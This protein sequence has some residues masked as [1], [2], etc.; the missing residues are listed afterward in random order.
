MKYCKKCLQPDTRPNTVF[1]DNGIC[2]ACNYFEKL[3]EVDWKERRDILLD[4]AKNFPK[5]KG[6]R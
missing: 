6:Q 2:P 5:S 4:L 1:E 3:G